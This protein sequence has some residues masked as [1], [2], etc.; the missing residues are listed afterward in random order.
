[1]FGSVRVVDNS[2]AAL[3]PQFCDSHPSFAGKQQENI[4]AA[5]PKKLF[6]VTVIS[7]SELG[8]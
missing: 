3:N 7:E 5:G 1:V 6:W 8:V 4:R 2:C